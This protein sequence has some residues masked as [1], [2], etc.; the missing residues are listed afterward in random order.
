MKKKIMLLLILT[1]ILVMPT[2]FPKAMSASEITSR[3]VCPNIELALAKTDGGLE[4]VD[5]YENYDQAK[6]AMNNDQ[7][8]DLVLI[9]NGMIIN[10]KYAVIDYDVSYTNIPLGYIN[11]YDGATSGNSISYIRSTQPD[12]AAVLDYDYNSKRIKIKVA[13]LVGWINKT[14][15]GAILYDV[16]P[17]VWAPTAQ[18]Y[19]VENNEL[20]HYTPGNV[21]GTKGEYSFTID[22]KPD[23]LNSDTKYYSY[24]GHYFYT[25]IKTMIN[26][27][28]NNTYQNSVNASNPYYNYYQYI[29]FR[30][31]TIYNA[32]NINQYINRGTGNSTTSK[33]YN[34][35][36]AFINAQNKYGANAILML[37]IGIN[38][39]GWGN[40]TIS[41]DKNNLFGL[42]AVDNNP[43]LQSGTF[44]TPADCIDAFAYS[45]LSYGFLQP[46][47][48]R[49]RGANLGNKAEGLNL[50]YASDPFWAEKATHYYYELDK[51]FD[52]QERKQNQYTIAVLKDNN[53]VYA[54]KT[55]NGADIDN[56]TASNTSRYYK[57]QTKDSAVVV[58]AEE[59][60]GNNN[61]W[62]KIQSDPTLTPNLSYTNA[63]SK[64]SPRYE[65]NWNS[66]VYVPS[67]AFNKVVIGTVSNNT[68][69]NTN[70]NN[71]ENNNNNNNNQNQ[72][73]EETKVPV[74]SVVSSANYGYDSGIISGISL[75]TEVNTVI[76]T[77]TNKGAQ[78]VIITTESGGPKSGK[79]GTGDKITVKTNAGTETLTVV[80][81]GD[82]TGDGE[83][84]SADLLRIRQH[85]LGQ[86][87]EG[88]YKKAAYIGYNEINSANLLKIR[89]YLLGQ[90]DL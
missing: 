52:F 23:M 71:N 41:Q 8:E 80:I 36:Q 10:A 59:K 88:A 45:W 44:E 85:L 84:N 27:Y 30:T 87:L 40:S 11:V 89:K 78:S 6:Q 66:F 53:T 79:L 51:L 48:W 3:K 35:G 46:G 5:C 39:S 55:P 54:K 81:S 13:G 33:L 50:K 82:L 83:I 56:E 20:R 34:T 19:K 62:Y 65:Y 18:Y 25:N 90:T 64:S 17:V 76:N 49:F 28:K 14:D 29:S 57:Y 70:T 77:L 58:L 86:S 72:Q 4:K 22:T 1:F 74:S 75:N 16:I 7:R 24:D 2:Y 60:D 31:K 26:D 43:Y 9:E 47:D 15:N 32:N 67:S 12:D 69:N 38:E 63:D 68:S 21:F 61:V 42:G 73:P 37:A